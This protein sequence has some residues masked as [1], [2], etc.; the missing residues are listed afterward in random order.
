MVSNPLASVCFFYLL[1]RITMSKTTVAT[2]APKAERSHVTALKTFWKAKER[3][4]A[5]LQ[6]ATAL[7]LVLAVS[8]VTGC[9]VKH[10]THHL[11]KTEWILDDTH[12]EFQGAKTMM[13]DI[14]GRLSG[15][16]T[17]SEKQAAAKAEVAK[18]ADADDA[19]N[20]FKALERVVK[21]RAKLSA[22]DRR[23]FG[24]LAAGL[25]VSFV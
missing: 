1:R 8:E 6:G 13:R 11:A 21:G 14:R 3:F 4:I 2:V 17:R 16:M 7:Q 19:A 5:A 9:A 22:A 15:Q 10:T 20:L 23:R 24:K 25:G 18:A 12:A